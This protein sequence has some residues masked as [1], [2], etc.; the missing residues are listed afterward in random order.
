MAQPTVQA[1]LDAIRVL[2]DAQEHKYQ[3]IPPH[4]LTFVSF[5]D[6]SFANSR[7]LSSHQGVFLAATTTELR[8]NVEAKVSPITWISK[9][10]SRVVLSTLS[11]EAYALFQS[12]DMLGWIRILWGCIHLADFPWKNF[13]I[14]YDKLRAAILVTDCKSLFDLVTRTAIHSCEKYRTTLEVLLIR[15]RCAEHCLFR[16]VPTTLMV[17]DC[18]TKSMNA[19]LLRKILT[20]GSLNFMTL[21]VIVSA[22]R[23]VKKPYNGYKIALPLQ[24][25]HRTK[26]RQRERQHSGITFDV[27]CT[28][29][30]ST[31]ARGGKGMGVRLLTEAIARNC[32][33]E[34]T[35]AGHC[36]S[37]RRGLFFSSSLRAQIIP[38]FGEAVEDCEPW[39]SLWGLRPYQW[40][41]S[42]ESSQRQSL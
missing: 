36:L 17:A 33:L 1:L 39:D 29:Y 30:H 14:T 6:A 20:L 40:G 5:G 37:L 25:S 27:I 34:K 15:Q 23:I 22:T 9:K 41:D 21:P 2:R 8:H 12:V 28:C 19:D 26:Y 38:G 3:S 13:E 4:K 11:A 32:W 18:L 24:M 16:W 10:M 31:A 7:N 42:H 35:S